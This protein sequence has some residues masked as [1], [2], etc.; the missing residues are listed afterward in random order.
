MLQVFR[1]APVSGPWGC[2][3]EHF[4]LG[5]QDVGGRELELCDKPQGGQDEGL[6]A[7]AAYWRPIE[8]QGQMVA[9]G[10]ALAN[11]LLQ[12]SLPLPYPVVIPR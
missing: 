3:E 10:W 5:L 9:R 1:G 8:D 6:Y 12:L 4:C 7:L 11:G 2:L